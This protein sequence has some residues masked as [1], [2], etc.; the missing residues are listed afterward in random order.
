MRVLTRFYNKRNTH[1]LSV[2]WH[3]DK[4]NVNGVIMNVSIVITLYFVWIQTKEATGWNVMKQKYI[5]VKY[6]QA[7]IG[8]LKSCFFKRWASLWIRLFCTILPFWLNTK[9]GC[10][11]NIRL[12]TYIPKQICTYV[13]QQRHFNPR[14]YYFPKYY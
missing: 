10:Y 8:K 12:T 5:E 13:S 11:G 7:I 1:I 6:F 9:V 2:I 4:H 3:L 14:S